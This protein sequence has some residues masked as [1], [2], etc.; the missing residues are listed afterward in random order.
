MRTLTA[1]VCLLAYIC[2]GASDELNIDSQQLAI[3]LALGSDLIW[4]I[5]AKYPTQ[6][7][8]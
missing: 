2:V 6:Q 8:V 1:L 7:K 3:T 4:N 5:P